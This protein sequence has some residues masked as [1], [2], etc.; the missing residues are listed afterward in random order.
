MKIFH[1]LAGEGTNNRMIMWYIFAKSKEQVCPN[2]QNADQLK[3]LK[4]VFTSAGRGVV[5]KN[6]DSN[7][8][9]PR[10]E[11]VRRVKKP[12]RFCCIRWAFH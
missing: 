12:P 2:V 9:V 5:A 3:L 8:P 7:L 4:T 1:L 10:R 6:A 11:D